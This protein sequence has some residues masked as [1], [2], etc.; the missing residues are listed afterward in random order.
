MTRKITLIVWIAYIHTQPQ[1]MLLILLLLGILT[2][3]IHLAE[4]HQ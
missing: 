3:S 4:F 2:D 1:G